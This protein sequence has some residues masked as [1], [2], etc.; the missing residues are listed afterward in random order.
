MANLN[1]TFSTHPSIG[2][3]NSNKTFL[4]MLGCSSTLVSWQALM[5]QQHCNQSRD[6]FAN[7]IRF[8]VQMQQYLMRCTSHFGSCIHGKGLKV[9][10]FNTFFF[11]TLTQSRKRTWMGFFLFSISVKKLLVQ[12]ISRLCCSRVVGKVKICCPAR[13]WVIQSPLSGHKL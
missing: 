5:A 4:K 7:C 13:G 3:Y 6:F 1:L 9:S 11:N 10:G 12:K 8:W 2:F